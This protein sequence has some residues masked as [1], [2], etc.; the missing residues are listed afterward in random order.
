MEISSHGTSMAARL[1]LLK[2]QELP[3]MDIIC[4][5]RALHAEMHGAESKQK[6]HRPAPPCVYGYTVEVPE[7]PPA[8]SQLKFAVPEVN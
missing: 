1:I 2:C 6:K 4:E 5:W 7:E 3:V 8:R